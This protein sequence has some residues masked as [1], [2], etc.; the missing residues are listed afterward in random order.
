ML[1]LQQKKIGKLIKFQANKTMPFG[2]KILAKF[3]KFSKDNSL[4]SQRQYIFWK[5]VTIS[6]RK[7]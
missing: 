3:R 2:K 5:D 6:Y 1:N 4:A 7:Q